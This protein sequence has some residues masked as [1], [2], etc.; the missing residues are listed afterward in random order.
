M[1]GYQKEIL[2]LV[3]NKF[4]SGAKE[5]HIVA[6]PG[7]G[8]TIIG[9]QIL[10]QLKKPGL[11]LSPNTTIQSQ[12]SQKISL[13]LPENSSLETKEIIGTQEDLPLKPITTLTYQVLSTASNEQEYIENLARKRWIDELRTNRGLSVGEAEIRILELYQNNNAAYKKEIS[14]HTTKIRRK[15][16]RCIGCGRGSPQERSGDYSQPEK[17]WSGNNHF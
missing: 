5:I 14:R 17:K 6:P 11:I 9:L 8:K 7:A 1:R 10:T 3:S 2:D 16:G 12:W 15:V 4:N 13:F